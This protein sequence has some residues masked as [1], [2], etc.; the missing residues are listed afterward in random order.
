HRPAALDP[1][2]ANAGLTLLSAALICALFLV[3]LVL[4][5]VWRLTPIAAAAVV[6]TI[7][8]TT[9][10]AERVVRGYSPILM[11]ALGATLVATGLVG[12]SFVG[13]REIVLVTI[14][15]ALVGTGLG[16]AFPGLTTAA[17]HGHGPAA[18]RAAK[19]IAARE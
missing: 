1:A 3:V 11:G 9:A 5:D 12:L 19:T 13:H 15:L 4:I 6:T 17:L 16:M 7:P 10:L 2:T 14:T 8:L 18:G